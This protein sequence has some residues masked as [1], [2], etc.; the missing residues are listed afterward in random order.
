MALDV[1]KDILWRIY[2]VYI[3]VFLIACFIVARVV[4][5]QI[6]EGQYWKERQNELT[7]HFANIEAVRGNIFDVNG[8]L[9]ATSLP[10]YDVAV[11]M[12]ADAITDDIFEDNLDSLS[13]SLSTLFPDRNQKQFRHLLL[14]AKNSGDRYYMLRE[15][16]SYK[17][18]Q[19]LKKF[20]LF[21][22]GQYKGG[23]IYT[24]KGLRE[25]PFKLLASRT[26]GSYRETAKP[27]GLEGSFNKELNGVSGKRLV[28]K[29]AGRV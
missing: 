18:L 6:G 3:F 26:I 12:N 24:Q 19:E 29:I 7:L 1:R 17:E 27:I 10:Y 28:R 4:K 23:L 20:P 8:Q 14:D 25:L 9:L 22:K 13:Y 2:L 11:D 5:I 16:V 15:N 21:R